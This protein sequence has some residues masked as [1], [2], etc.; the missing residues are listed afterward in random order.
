[1]SSELIHFENRRSSQ[2]YRLRYISMSKYEGDWQSQPHTHQFSELF[3]VLSGKG[4][5]YIEG[6]VI[7]VAPN[8]LMIINP[9]IEHTEKT[10]PSDPLEYI[11]FG[12]DGLAF[13]FATSADGTRCEYGHYNYNSAKSHFINFSKIMA[14]E[15][16]E[17]RPGFETICHG[18]LEALLVYITR[19]QDFSLISDTT[20]AISKDCAIA[21]R[22]IDANYAKD[23]TLDRLAKLTHINKYY[24]A[25]SFAEYVGK[26]P[27]SYLIETRLNASK[28][29]LTSSDKS[30]ADIAASTGFSS[31][32]YFSQVFRKNVG[33][34][35]QE[36]RK[37]K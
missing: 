7:P 16:G 1:M 22:Y 12:V 31:Q 5:F 10:T 9:N 27:I 29:L 14:R 34:S 15:F 20:L 13:S 2:D 21:K 19:E 11:V 6:D 18:L 8:D 4:F 3:Y 37:G 23:I 32:S 28:Q 36:Y 25:H 24:L 30:I 35:P 17:K 33:M 26:S